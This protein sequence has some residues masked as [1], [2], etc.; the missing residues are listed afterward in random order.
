M[1]VIGSNCFKGCTKLKQ[2]TFP[3]SL[4][5]L[6]FG[7][8]EGCASLEAVDFTAVS[9]LKKIG[10]DA[11]AGIPPLDHNKLKRVDLPEGLEV[12]G[13]RAFSGCFDLK[14][15]TLPESLKVIEQ[16]AFYGS[17]Q[18]EQINFP[19]GLEQIESHAFAGSCK[20][21]AIPVEVRE[22]FNLQGLR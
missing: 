4:E 11:F 1:Q 14:V 7:T 18:L 2:V 10:S 13:E 9:S 6:G 20:A 22:K 15:V 5:K 19:A 21:D 12:I 8:F 16:A 3:A 17:D